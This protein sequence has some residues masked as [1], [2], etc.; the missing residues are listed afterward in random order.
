MYFS[1]FLSAM[2]PKKFS[3]QSPQGIPKGF[4]KSLSLMQIDPMKIALSALFLL[5]W[6]PEDHND[7]N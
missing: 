1:R 4:I 5:T 3:A 6:I 2:K 7:K